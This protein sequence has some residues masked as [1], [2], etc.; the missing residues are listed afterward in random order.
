MVLGSHPRRLRGR[1]ACLNRIP[2]DTDRAAER[3]EPIWVEEGVR[4][5]K[6]IKMNHDRE[7]G[8][9]KDVKES[10]K[11]TRGKAN[12]DRETKRSGKADQAEGKVQKGVGK[13]STPSGARTDRGNAGDVVDVIKF[14]RSAA[15]VERLP[16]P[17]VGS[18]ASRRTRRL[19]EVA[20][21]R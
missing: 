8:K 19:A 21:E 10:A 5:K 18:L 7:E 12:G 9:A 11:E 17:R 20:P 4:R 14:G 16:A 15:T 6:N 3:R 2:S 13:A 1:P